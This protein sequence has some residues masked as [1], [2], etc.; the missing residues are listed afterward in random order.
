M[1]LTRSSR[2]IRRKAVEL[3]EGRAVVHHATR[4]DHRGVTEEFA[5]HAFVEDHTY[6][7][8]LSREEAEE[9]ALSLTYMLATDEAEKVA[10]YQRI[11]IWRIK[12]RVERETNEQP[13]QD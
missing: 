2:K 11:Q 6:N 1:K 12:V 9:L 4:H 7:L 13:A 5:I 3:G 10:A 8:E